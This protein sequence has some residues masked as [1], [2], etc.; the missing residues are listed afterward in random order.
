MEKQKLNIHAVMGRFFCSKILGH[1]VNLGHTDSGYL[2]CERCG[3][4]EYYD[5]NFGSPALFL[6]PKQLKWWAICKYRELRR[7]D[8][9]PF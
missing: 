7:S 4:H 5:S 8:D 6:I 2:V 9:L 1:N 3:M